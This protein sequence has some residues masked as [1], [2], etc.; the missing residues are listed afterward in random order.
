MKTRC[1]LCNEVM[2][3]IPGRPKVCKNCKTNLAYLDRNSH[4]AERKLSNLHIRFL[5]LTILKDN[6]KIS[7][8]EALRRAI[9]LNNQQG[10]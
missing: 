10:V 9:Q 2:P 8:T 5:A 4:Q 3:L 7:I 6:L 1:Y